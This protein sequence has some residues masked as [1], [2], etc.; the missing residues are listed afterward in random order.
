MDGVQLDALGALC[1]SSLRLHCRKHEVVHRRAKGEYC[2]LV[3]PRL[4]WSEPVL[5]A[6]RESNPQPAD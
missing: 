2:S 3:A 5:C 1:W 4:G 6:A